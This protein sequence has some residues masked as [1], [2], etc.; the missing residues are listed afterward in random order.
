MYSILIV[1]DEKIERNGIKFLLKQSGMELNV[2]EASNGMQALEFL[3]EHSVDIMLTDVKMPFMDGIELIKQVRKTGK[4]LNIVIFSGYSEFE[5]ARMAVKLN[6]ND[7]ILKPVDPKE[8]DTVLRRI[9]EK[10][11]SEDRKEAISETSMHHMQEHVLYL[12]VNGKPREEVEQ[13]FKKLLNLDFLDQ[14]ER[15][16]LL[17]FN[18]DFFGKM[19]NDVMEKLQKEI[20]MQFQYLN[21]NQQQG[22]L[23]FS[24]TIEEMNYEEI[25]KKIHTFFQNTVQECCFVAVSSQLEG[26]NMLAKGYEELE[27]LMENKFYQSETFVYKANADN[28]VNTLA[29]IDDDTLMKQMKQDIKM[30]DISSLNEHF[31]RLCDK[32][33][34]NKAFSQVYIKFI[35]SNLLKDF[36][37][38]LPDMKEAQLNDEVDRLYRAADFQSVM[39]IVNTNIDRLAKAFHQN[40]QMFHREIE[41]VKQ[42]IY[43]N[44]D[45]ELGVEQ[46]AEKVALAP[47]YLSHIFKK[48]TGQNLSK[49]I[50][51]Y[52]ME[53]AKKKLEET[54]EK[55]VNIS[56][57]VGYVNVSYF[58]QSFREYFG[59]SPQKFR[60]QGECNER[61]ASEVDSQI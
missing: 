60:N 55:I 53:M 25:G 18:N 24:K 15:M 9:I 20:N 19:G 61:K 16:I 14:Y 43:A 23:L 35:F 22:L 28:N 51:A 11:E 7:Y 26:E 2:N 49:F 39:E 31:K 3:K 12:L 54:H 6:V 57:A 40:P 41:S 5:Y 56:Y 44:Y 4:D 10:L 52:R 8:F 30:K 1:D 29:Q 45:K 42:Y 36:Y 48:E 50:K 37:E 17:E 34:K 58:C 13:E 27:E 33:R 32:Y 47:S 59:V 38:N 21:L 46:L